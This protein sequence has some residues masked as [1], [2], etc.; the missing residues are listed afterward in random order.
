[1]K[2]IR[3]IAGLGA[4]ALLLASSLALG[5]GLFPGLPI[6]GGASYCSSVSGT[7]GGGQF[8]STCNVTVP[9]G[10]SALTGNEL[11]PADTQLPS[12]QS[13]QTVAIPTSR[14]GAGPTTYVVPLTGESATITNTTRRLNINPAGTIAAFTLVFPAA[15]TLTQADGQLFGFCTTQIVTT[16]TVTDGA[17]TTVLNKPSAMLVPVA[18]GGA[19]CVEWQYRLSNTT[20]YRVQ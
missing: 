2:S 14:L 6:V 3:R 12:G 20:W 13:P 1:M 5:A 8:G 19:S 16:L 17:G 11:I 9:A 10:P 18:T 4:A 15:S 7:G